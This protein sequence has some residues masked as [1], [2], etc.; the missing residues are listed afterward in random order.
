MS[1]YLEMSNN[2][3]SFVSYYWG[4]YVYHSKQKYNL[5]VSNKNIIF[6]RDFHLCERLSL[7]VILDNPNN[8]NP[9]LFY[10]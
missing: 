9:R 1:K 8:R 4:N 2:I 3:F 7:G 10:F 6:V 5:I